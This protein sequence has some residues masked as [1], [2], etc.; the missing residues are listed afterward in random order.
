VAGVAEEFDP[1]FFFGERATADEFGYSGVGPHGAAGG[2]IFEAMVAET[3]ARSFD[4]G[5]IPGL[6][7]RLEH[8]K[9]LAQGR[10][11]IWNREEERRF[12]RRVSEEVESA[13]I[14]H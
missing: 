2:E 7:Q 13:R 9:I 14:R 8:Q 12:G 10:A 1:G 6:R 4:H 5:K 11:K 3:E